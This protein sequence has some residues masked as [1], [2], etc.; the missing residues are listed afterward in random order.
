L[1]I[2]TLHELTDKST[3][4]VGCG[5]SSLFS[6]I[7]FKN[8]NNNNN[9]KIY[10]VFTFKKIIINMS[11]IIR[12]ITSIGNKLEDCEQFVGYIRNRINSIR[13]LK[14]LT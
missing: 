8:N 3:S 10:L 2:F 6:F 4:A 1:L 12:N 9:S 11:K 13:Q 7:Y 5:I 14:K